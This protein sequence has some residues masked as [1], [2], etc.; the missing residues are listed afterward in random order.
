MQDAGLFY[1]SPGDT[2]AGTWEITDPALQL[3][4]MRRRKVPQGDQDKV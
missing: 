4:N 2:C 1:A 3:L